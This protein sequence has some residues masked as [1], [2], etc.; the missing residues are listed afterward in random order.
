MSISTDSCSPFFALVLM[1]SFLLPLLVG[2]TGVRLRFPLT[3]C[4]DSSSS[5]PLVSR[6]SAVAVTPED[7]EGAAVVRTDMPLLGASFL[8][9][10]SPLPPLV[11]STGEVVTSAHKASMNKL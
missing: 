1:V 6:S 9:D 8:L 4:G 7:E 10:D 2:R 11:T 3:G 5:C